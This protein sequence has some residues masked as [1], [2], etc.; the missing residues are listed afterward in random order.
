MAA[1]D[2]PNSPVANDTFS[3]SGKKWLY[4]GTTWV[5]LGVSTIA[6]NDSYNLDG[7]LATTT[8]GGIS[9]LDGGGATG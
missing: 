3:A 7:G 1:I 4:N 8:Y 2:F 6:P 9:N 5:L